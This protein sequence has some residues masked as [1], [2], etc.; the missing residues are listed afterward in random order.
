[1][2]EI[3]V[4]LEKE[5][6]FLNQTFKSKNGF[7]ELQHT[8]LCNE[9]NFFFHCYLATSMTNYWA[10]IF[11]RLLFYAYVGIHKVSIEDSCLWQLPRVYAAFKQ[12]YEIMTPIRNLTN[13]D[14]D[15]CDTDDTRNSR[16][17][18][19]ISLRRETRL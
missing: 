7:G 1:M 2:F 19:V 4:V 8:I 15:T 9:G 16:Q 14:V 5:V 6:F 13:K 3:T 17:Q 12:L 10:H 11:K 18:E